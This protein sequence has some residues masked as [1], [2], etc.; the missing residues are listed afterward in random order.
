MG[1][2]ELD[3]N[4]FR[5]RKGRNNPP[6][7]ADAVAHLIQVNERAR[8][9]AGHVCVQPLDGVL[10]CQR[11]GPSLPLPDGLER[12]QVGTIT[13]SEQCLL[14]RCRGNRHSGG[15]PRHAALTRRYA[16]LGDDEP[17]GSFRGG[18]RWGRTPFSNATLPWVTLWIYPTGVE[19]GC[20]FRWWL[21]P[22]VP[23]WLARY[24]E[25]AAVQSVGRLDPDGSESAKAPFEARGIR[26]RGR[27]SLRPS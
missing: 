19:L 7:S 18:M 22:F 6:C 9:Q 8:L 27:M 13:T 16:D 23:G 3:G 20:T 1:T 5:C 12:A 26:A 25:L 15:M 4:G 2:G 10:G 14:F 17:V 21:T 11:R 24:E